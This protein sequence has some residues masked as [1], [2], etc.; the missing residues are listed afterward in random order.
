MSFSLHTV[1]IYRDCSVLLNEI[2]LSFSS[3]RFYTGLFLFSKPTISFEN[4][5]WSTSRCEKTHFNI[6][7]LSV[8]GFSCK[9][10]P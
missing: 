10:T 9:S 3:S 7:Q 4:I 5:F 2:N 1:Q 8:M 6:G